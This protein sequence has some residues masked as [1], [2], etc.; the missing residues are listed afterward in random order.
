MNDTELLSAIALKLDYLDYGSNPLPFTKMIISSYLEHGNKV[1][2]PYKCSSIILGCQVVRLSDQWL[3]YVVVMPK[4]AYDGQSKDQF[5]WYSGSDLANDECAIT[6]D[7]V[8]A[9]LINKLYPDVNVTNNGNTTTL[10]IRGHNTVINW[11][12]AFKK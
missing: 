8:S 10:N 12:S 6:P 11:G 4:G 2:V 1:V 5:I 7:D 9:Y 3:K